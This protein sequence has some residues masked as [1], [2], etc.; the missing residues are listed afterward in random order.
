MAPPK[1]QRFLKS[2][3]D[4]EAKRVREEKSVQECALLDLDDS[5]DIAASNKERRKGFMMEWK[6]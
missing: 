6:A 1:R 2:G 3:D 5:P 4:L